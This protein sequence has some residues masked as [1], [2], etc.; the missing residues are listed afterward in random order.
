MVTSTCLL[1]KQ[2]RT[3]HFEALGCGVR[4]ARISKPSYPCAVDPPLSAWPLS[5]YIITKSNHLMEV[6][7]TAQWTRS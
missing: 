4:T 7:L 2:R 1:H 6:T 3:S 5:G